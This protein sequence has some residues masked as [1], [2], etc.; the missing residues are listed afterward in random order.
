VW[1]VNAVQR[2]KTE[3]Y[4]CLI[5]LTNR[6]CYCTYGLVHDALKDCFALEKV[7]NELSFVTS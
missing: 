3:N 4:F 7:L 1:N 2:H 5:D 6:P